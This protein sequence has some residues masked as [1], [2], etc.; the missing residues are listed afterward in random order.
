MKIGIFSCRKYPRPEKV[1]GGVWLKKRLP[2]RINLGAEIKFVRIV[3]KFPI[4]DWRYAG[5]PFAEEIG[6][7]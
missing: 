7:L 5:S 1:V 3:L 2:V 6:G 4:G